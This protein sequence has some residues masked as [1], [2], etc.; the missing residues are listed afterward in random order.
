MAQFKG[1]FPGG[2]QVK[3]IHN[4]NID[5]NIIFENGDVYFATFFTLRNVESLMVKDQDIYFWATDLIIIKDL[6]RETIR[7]A[8]AK[9]VSDGYTDAFCKIGTIQTVYSEG[10]FPELDDWI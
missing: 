2:Y 7:E 5:V 8:I 9:I 1:I 3:D 4:D 10:T 6:R